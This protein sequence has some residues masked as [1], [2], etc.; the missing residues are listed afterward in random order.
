MGHLSEHLALVAPF[1]GAELGA[2]S[3]ARVRVWAPRC[4]RLELVVESAP[5]QQLERIGDGWWQADRVPLHAGKRYR[6]RLPDGRELPDPASCWQPGGVHGPSAAVDFSAFRAR[7]DGAWRGRELAQLVIYELHP[8]TFTPEGTFAAAVTRLDALAD[9]GITA[10]EVMPVSPCP[11]TRNWGYDGVFPFA[12]QQPYGG[13]W[14]MQEFVD[15]CHERG[16]AVLLDVV[17]NHFGPEGNVLAEFMP[18][19]ASGH[20]LPWGEAINLDGAGSTG[21]RA[22][23]LDS[24]R[25]WFARYHVDGLRLDA[26]HALTDASA[27][28]FL[29]ELADATRS[30]A[31][32]LGRPLHLI[33]ESDLNASRIVRPAGAGGYGLD[34][35]WSDDFHHALHA[36]LTGERKGYYAD[37][38][39]VDDLA[40]AYAR[41]FVLDGRRSAFRGRDWGDDGSDLPTACFTVC[42]QN[43]D[44]V[45]NRAGGE[46]LSVLTDGE[47]LKLAAAAVL[48]S[49]YLPLLFMGEEWGERTP[50]RFFADYGDAELAR[51]VSRSRA[52]QL[53]GLPGEAAAAADPILESTFTGSRLD[54]AAAAIEPGRTLRSFYRECLRWRACLPSL[55]PGPRAQLQVAQPAPGVIALERWALACHSLLLLNCAATMRRPVIPERPWEVA[56]ASAAARWNGPGWNDCRVHGS[57]NLPGRSAVLL[58]ALP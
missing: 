36:V 24:A 22:F 35:Q 2:D 4:R 30:W 57:L 17:Y 45:G 23:L 6:L 48:L 31:E 56:L 39:A 29:A 53:A 15:A 34:S 8:G 43:H 7:S 51:R 50:F 28:H 12:V 20:Q 14:G 16:L 41:G 52:E 10:V 33:A 5:A 58:R 44:Q 37:F 40:A 26:V 13:P 25:H 18:I 27:Q 49:P 32:E 54:W 42:A 46:R 38:G 21:V 1:P 47:G 19:T 9:L 3:Q 55:L 11:G